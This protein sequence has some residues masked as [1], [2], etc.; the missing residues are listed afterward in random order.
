MSRHQRRAGYG[1]E[2]L[3]SYNYE[4]SYITQDGFVNVYT[5]TTPRMIQ[6]VFVVIKQIRKF[7]IIDLDT[8]KSYKQTN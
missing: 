8:L 6:V 1:I 3:S 4:C 2:I 7:W 5:R